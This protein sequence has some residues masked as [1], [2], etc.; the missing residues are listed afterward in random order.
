MDVL[1]NAVHAWK[2]DFKMMG[3]SAYMPFAIS[4]AY[5]LLQFL[6]G[7]LGEWKLDMVTRLGEILLPL[8]A[9]WWPVYLLAPMLEGEGGDMLFSCPTRTVVLGSLRICAYFILYVASI[10][11]TYAVLHVASGFP[12]GLL[13]LQ[14]VI[15][16]FFFCSFGFFLMAVTHNSGISIVVLFAYALSFQIGKDLMPAFLNVY[17]NNEAPATAEQLKSTILFPAL[18]S[19]IAMQILANLRIDALRNG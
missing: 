6:F 1:W 4:I 14:T 10:A 11:L 19:G 9:A 5:L 3:P 12:T 8:F 17:L 18:C 16:S 7:L 13:F 2:T 15:Q